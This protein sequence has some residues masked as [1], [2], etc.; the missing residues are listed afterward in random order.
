[1]DLMA[2]LTGFGLAAGVGAR[3]FIPVLAL[4]LFHY[5]EWFELSDRFAWIASPPVLV[6]LAVLTLVELWVDAHPE[7]GEYADL[8]SYAPKMAGGFIAFAAATGTVDQSLVELAGS[9]LL[10]TMTAT[11]ST[12]VRNRLRAPVRE[13]AAGMDGG[14]GGKIASLGEAGVAAG[15]SAGA[16]LVPAVAA[17]VLVAVGTGG[18]LLGSRLGRSRVECVACHKPIPREAVVCGHCS[19]AQAAQ[20]VITGQ[21]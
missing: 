7:L 4:G 2:M 10:G 11:A 16:I 5:T 18:Y 15:V 12:Y 14:L 6:T 21:A 3:A 19:A 1:M 13:V 17:V 20:P 9:G 8:A